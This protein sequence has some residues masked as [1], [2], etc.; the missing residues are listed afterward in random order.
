MKGKNGNSW[1][2]LW[3]QSNFLR[4]PHYVEAKTLAINTM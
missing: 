1:K 4:R 2:K 3:K